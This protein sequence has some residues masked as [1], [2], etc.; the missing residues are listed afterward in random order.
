MDSGPGRQRTH[1]SRVFPAA[2]STSTPSIST[3]LIKEDIASPP[4]CHPFDSTLLT[5]CLGAQS[6]ANSPCRFR[7]GD[8]S[9]SASLNLTYWK[10]I[11][12]YTVPSYI[13]R[14]CAIAERRLKQS[15]PYSRG[16][17]CW[18]S[19]FQVRSLSFNIIPLTYPFP[20]HSGLWRG[21][22][23]PQISC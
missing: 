3:S 17:T 23:S 20:C 13:S 7:G 15:R 21:Y 16:P 14:M 5:T 22:P 1:E 18:S 11:L 12:A 10:A 19:L 2:L 6:A 8:K 4:S 9:T